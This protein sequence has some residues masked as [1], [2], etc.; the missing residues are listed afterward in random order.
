[1]DAVLSYHFVLQGQPRT[2]PDDGLDG[3]LEGFEDLNGTVPMENL[4]LP[5]LLSEEDSRGSDSPKFVDMDGSDTHNDTSN[6]S[7]DSEGKSDYGDEA[8]VQSV[9]GDSSPHG[10]SG[11]ILAHA[12]DDIGIGVLFVYPAATRSS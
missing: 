11:L 3:L 8:E 4:K 7:S 2:G 1:M 12:A 5:Q 10:S 9:S 6:E